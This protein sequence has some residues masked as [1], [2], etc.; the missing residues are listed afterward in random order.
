[1]KIIEILRLTEQGFSQRDIAKSAGCSKSTAGEIQKRCREVGISYEM[2]EALPYEELK[3][4][5]YPAATSQYIKQEPDFGTVY[6]E[7]RRHPKLNLRF[8]WDE[9]KSQ[10]PDGLEYSWF[11]EKFSRWMDIT[12]KHVT[13]HQEREA[14][15]ELFVDWMGDT[16]PAV[17]NPVTGEASA[18]HF[19]VCALGNSGYPYVEA[20]SDEKSDKWLTAHIHAFDY[21]GGVPRIVVPDNCKT[22]V[23]KPQHYDPVINPAYWELAKHYG[24]AVIP[25]RI[26]E[27]QDK[28]I[29][30]ESVGWLETWL[31]GWLRNQQFFSFAELNLSIKKRLEEL[32][33]R[34][35][36]KRPGSR[37]SI[38]SEVD[39]PALRP[40]NPHRFE[41]ADMVLRMVPDNYHVEYDGFYY[42][43]P[44]TFYRKRVTLRATSTTIEVFDS[45]RT[46]IA[47][48]ARR[49]FGLRYVTDP[50]HMPEKHRRY[51]ESKQFNGARY[52]SWAETIGEN[53]HTLID[54]MLS[55][56][57]IE[58][59]AYKA[60]MGLLQMSKKYG[61]ERLE[62]ACARAYRLQSCSY[63][64]V[65]NIL[66][67][68]IDLAPQTPSSE[69]ALPMHENVRG[70][71]YY[72]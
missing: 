30:E 66:K 7:L 1:M 45:N 3:K 67:N 51:W 20:F 25:A 5:V 44:Y 57:K 72:A 49:F 17:I 19:F 26:R 28:A 52:R 9:Y 46:R 27:P 70:K 40:L 58:E 36:Q 29:V 54:R 18:A 50:A 33:S 16:L 13:M 11:C 34:S 6:D 35:Y 41:T 22:A 38:F 15:K 68:G 8:L 61:N 62:N 60:C 37:L 42:S 65:A 10:H 23:N 2:A 32:V 55:A 53:T 69:K 14:G 64:T 39:E 43:V 21:Y 24:V 63:T 47:S 31:L 56:Q 4:L 48:H 71:E 59:Q 12:G